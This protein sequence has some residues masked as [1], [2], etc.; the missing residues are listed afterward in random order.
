MKYLHEQSFN[1][2][3]IKKKEEVQQKKSFG[4]VNTYPMHF[5]TFSAHSCIINEYSERKKLCIRLL[6][7]YLL[8]PFLQTILNVRLKFVLGYSIS[9]LIN[10][11]N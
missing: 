8:S 2:E 7:Y 3:N 1:D 11:H 4:I 9:P 10:I 6:F 5:C